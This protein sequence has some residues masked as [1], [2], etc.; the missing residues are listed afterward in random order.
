[1]KFHLEFKIPK[2]V[3][4]FQH[5]DGIV[6]MGSCFTEN[7]GEK[8]LK[9]K[10]TVTENP[11]GILFNPISVSQAI[12]TCVSAKKI[13]A[14]DLFCYQGI[15]HS[16]MHHSRFSNVCQ[17]D[18]LQRINQSI[19][20]AHHALKNAN[21]LVITLGSAWVYQLTELAIGK[22]GMVVAN[23][24]KA[25]ANWFSRSLL[26]SELLTQV[27]KEMVQSL[28]LFNQH[29][30][31]IFTISPVRHLREGVVDNNRSKAVLIQSVHE[32][33]AANEACGYFPAYELVIDDL[34]DYRFYAEDLVHPNYQATQYVWEKFV[35][36]GMGLETKE[37]MK[38]I[39]E[40]NI[41]FQHKPFQPTTEQHQAFLKNYW[42]KTNQL[43]EKYPYLDFKKEINYFSAQ[44]NP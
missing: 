20:E 2:F 29:L 3:K 4:P 27:L 23:N 14:E 42:Q 43:Q 22:Q 35:E 31:I 15:W 26:N 10:F 21:H 13:S 41:A 37:M 9:H 30:Q 5:T 28:R 1:M 25:P 33:V 39:A 8:L 36:A 7:I 32:L 16:W 11:N 24:H 6:L 44:L 38:Q 17:S 12:E 40:I 19:E 34:R 18:C